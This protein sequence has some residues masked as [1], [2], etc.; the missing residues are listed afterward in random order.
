MNGPF[1]DGINEKPFIEKSNPQHYEVNHQSYRQFL[2]LAVDG[3]TKHTPYQYKCT[4]PK[5]GLLNRIQGDK[6]KGD[7]NA[8]DEEI[9]VEMKDGTADVTTES[10]TEDTLD[11]TDQKINIVP[12]KPMI[13]EAILNRFRNPK[14]LYETIVQNWP[15]SSNNPRK[16]LVAKMLELVV[17][18]VFPKHKTKTRLIAFGDWGGDTLDINR[19]ELEGLYTVKYM[20]QQIKNID[21]ILFLGD[22]VYD[23]DYTKLYSTPKPGEQLPQTGNVDGVRDVI[24]TNAITNVLQH[25][26]EYLG[27]FANEFAK[28]ITGITQAVPFMVLYLLI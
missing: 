5:I 20:L 22:L 26:V 6:L 27:D 24:I 17:D 18:Y 25:Y 4:Y 14:T 16:K 3:L 8:K 21:A 28:N 15:R 11:S 12:Q 2:Y 9:T 10:T 7:F 19:N 13:K 1:E 23:L